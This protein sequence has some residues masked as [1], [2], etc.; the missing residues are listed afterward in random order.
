MS[1]AFLEMNWSIPETFSGGGHV[2]VRNVFPLSRQKQGYQDIHERIKEL[3]QNPRRAKAL[4]R[5]RQ[6]LAE[7]LYPPH[8]LAALR[9]KKGLSQTGLARMIG[10]SQSR[11]SRLES[12]QDKPLHFTVVKLSEALG[13]SL[14]TI[15]RA[16]KGGTP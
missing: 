4:E 5:A 1:L 16:M 13:E 3:E 7:E 12:G 15:S 9:L 6:E 14:E 2:I 10:T 11:L 8:S